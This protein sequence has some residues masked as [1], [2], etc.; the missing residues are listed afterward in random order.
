MLNIVQPPLKALNSLCVLDSF[1]K[2]NLKKFFGYLPLYGCPYIFQ[3]VQ[4]NI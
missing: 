3:D 1:F 2:A 4:P